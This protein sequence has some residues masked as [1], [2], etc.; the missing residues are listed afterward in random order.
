[1]SEFRLYSDQEDAIIN[2]EM[3][4]KLPFIQVAIGSEEIDPSLRWLLENMDCFGDYEKENDVCN[5]NCSLE[6]GCEAYTKTQ[7]L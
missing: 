3:K 4:R 6:T 1:M 5:G 7:G 2:A